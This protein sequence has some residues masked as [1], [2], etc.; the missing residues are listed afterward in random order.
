MC[1]FTGA[2]PGV[3]L[4]F[5]SA[6]LP[7]CPGRRGVIVPVGTGSSESPWP[8][9][10]CDA[11]GV[12]TRSVAAHLPLG[13]SA[14]ATT[15]GEIATRCPLDPHDVDCS[16]YHRVQLHASGQSPSVGQRGRHGCRRWRRRGASRTRPIQRPGI[17]SAT[18]V[19][20]S[21]RSGLWSTPLAQNGVL[22]GHGLVASP[23]RG[24]RSAA[25]RERTLLRIG[26]GSFSPLRT[27][28]QGFRE[29]RATYRS[30]CWPDYSDGCGRRTGN[31][32]SSAD[33]QLAIRFGALRNR[34]RTAPGQRMVHGRVLSRHP[35]G[36]A[37]D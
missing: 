28:D 5:R 33:T 35:R 27:S 14:T 11:S 30:S 17:T 3:M 4:N 18:A 10:H 2:A 29:R 32:A 34:R 25:D 37:L 12:E 20:R 13:S 6:T 26:A 1:A 9:Y 36:L 24:G 7:S 21:R 8:R 31:L 16:G 23:N 15:L 22:S 19:S